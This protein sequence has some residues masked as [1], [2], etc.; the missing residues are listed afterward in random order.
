[1]QRL[2]WMFCL[3]IGVGFVAAAGAAGVDAAKS[4][5]V[6][7]AAEAFAALAK[8]AYKTGQPPRQ[9]DPAAKPLLDAVFNTTGVSD[10]AP[11]SLADM[12]VL[13]E[14]LLRTISVGSVYLLAGTN[15]QDPAH[16]A[17]L[18]EQQQSQI[19]RNTAAFAPEIGRYFDAEIDL[20][21]AIIDG[22]DAEM[23]LHP[24]KYQSPQSQSGL[25]KIKGGVKQTLAGALTTFL[26][27]GI[28]AAWM[29]ER[30]RVLAS[31]APSVARSLPAQDRHDLAEIS[32]QVAARVDDAEVKRGL[33]S[34]AKAVSA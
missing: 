28:S 25:A 19:T 14:W 12:D 22:V 9:T 27:P 3:L 29:Q 13:K 18:D 6:N 15:I 31:I 1:M 2:V 5:A 32:R 4:T 24:E 8:D 16:I 26:T 33:E 10:G 7:K 23:K 34:F 30:L 11:A 21:H 17:N 20:E